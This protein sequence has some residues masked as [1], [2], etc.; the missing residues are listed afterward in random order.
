MSRFAEGAR[1]QDSYQGSG[2]IR[3]EGKCGREGCA[4]L[5]SIALIVVIDATGQRRMGPA[6]EYCDEWNLRSGYHH[7]G[8]YERCAYCY[9]TDR[10]NEEAARLKQEAKQHPI[11]SWNKP[12]YSRITSRDAFVQHFGVRSVGEA[13]AKTLG[14]HKR[15]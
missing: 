1:R 5:A 9:S 7:G 4:N 11:P 2:V 15:D 12:P 14:G 8:W 6:S 10:M 3:P 13:L